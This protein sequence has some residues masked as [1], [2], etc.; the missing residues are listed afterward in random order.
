MIE[1]YDG[2]PSLLPAPYLARVYSETRD[3]SDTTADPT[4]PPADPHQPVEAVNSA[5]HTLVQAATGLVVI[6]GVGFYGARAA[7]H[8]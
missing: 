5:R 7:V 4:T 3:P 6:A 1:Q 8:R 2:R